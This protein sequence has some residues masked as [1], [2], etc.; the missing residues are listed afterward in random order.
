MIQ[1]YV[2]CT[3]HYQAITH[4]YTQMNTTNINLLCKKQMN[5]AIAH[6]PMFGIYEGICAFKQQQ[7]KQNVFCS[8]ITANWISIAK[9]PCQSFMYGE[10]KIFI[11]KL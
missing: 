8:M 6:W 7:Q 1:P 10:Y 2:I 5:R 3:Q 4:M 11:Q 9:L